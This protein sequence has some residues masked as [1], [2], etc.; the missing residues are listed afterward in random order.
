MNGS[1]LVGLEECPLHKRT[2]FGMTNVRM[3]QLSIARFYG[4]CRY[5]G[6]TYTYLPDTDELIRDDV[7]RWRFGQLKREAQNNQAQT[8]HD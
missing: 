8:R 4:A 7:L 6:D 5:N 3:T 1:A 2:P